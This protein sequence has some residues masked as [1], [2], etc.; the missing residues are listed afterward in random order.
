MMKLRMPMRNELGALRLVRKL[1]V[2]CCLPVCGWG[3]VSL[4]E[5]L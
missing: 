1:V 2:L 3:P 5:R 4:A